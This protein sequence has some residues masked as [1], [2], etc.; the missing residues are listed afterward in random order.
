LEPI[1]RA[2][3]VSLGPN[4]R[5]CFFTDAEAPRRLDTGYDIVRFICDSA[6]PGSLAPRVLRQIVGEVEQDLGDGTARL[7]I[8]LCAMFG[9]GVRQ[10]EAGIVPHRLADALNAEV[11]A[12]CL[13]LSEQRVATPDLEAVARTAGAEPPLARA[14]ADLAA[15]LGPGGTFEVEEGDRSGIITSSGQGYVFE[16]EPVSPLL[17]P[18]S[19]DPVHV[20]VA[21]EMIS[22]FGQLANVLEAFATRGKAL[23]I[24]ARDV[25]GAALQALVRNRAELGLRVAALRVKAAGEEAAETL[26]DIALATGGELICDS[27]GRTLEKLRPAMLGRAER[28]SFTSGRATLGEPAGEA[29]AIEFR[30]AYLLAEAE[31]KKYLSLDR[32]R[33]LRRASRLS[34]RWGELRV[35]GRNSWETAPLLAQARRAAAAV[36]S[37]NDGGAVAGGIDGLFDCLPSPLQGGNAEELAA[38]ACLRSALLALR[39][40][41][42]RNL[43]GSD[44]AGEGVLPRAGAEGFSGGEHVLDPLPISV[45]VLR[46]A[47]SGAAVL[48]LSDA[49]LSR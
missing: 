9:E 17:Q 23:V 43:A 30:R 42:R 39:C 12:F 1:A 44:E 22:D 4:A 47:A 35:A 34:G 49:F 40:G 48:L 37:A 5:A 2:V 19:L 27:E 33:L 29:D 45:S 20:L 38:R 31:R 41:I 16:A 32:E 11:S 28:F 8:S 46:R 18:V 36:R 10:V 6:G 24:I 3:G 21:N 15:K 25:T 13:H 26:R 7:A 14:I